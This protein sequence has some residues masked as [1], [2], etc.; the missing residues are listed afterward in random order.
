MVAKVVLYGMY[1]HSTV[2]SNPLNTNFL[3]FQNFSEFPLTL[4]IQQMIPLIQNSA[5][6]KDLRLRI[7]WTTR[8]CIGI[9]FPL[10][11][12]ASVLQIVI[13]STVQPMALVYECV[14]LMALIS[15]LLPCWYISCSLLVC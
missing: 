12:I 15:H 5:F 13:C 11:S 2:S 4:C 1:W 7:K 14:L 10:I 6:F 8:I 9:V 3:L